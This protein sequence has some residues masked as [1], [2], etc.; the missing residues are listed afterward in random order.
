MIDRKERIEEE[1]E[2]EQIIKAAEIIKGGGIVAFPTETV[3]GLGANA[4]DEKAVRKIFELKGRPQDNPLIV[5]ICSLDDLNIVAS[6]I[7]DKAYKLIE[8]FWPGPL[9]LVLTRNP[10]V[11]DIVSS[12]L[13]TVAVRMP[14]HPVALKLIRYAGTPIAAPSAN[15]S[16]KP[17]ATKPE[18]IKHYFGE[19]VFIVEGQTEIGIESTVLDMTS[20]QVVIL[21]PGGLELEKIREVLKEDIFIKTSDLPK[22]PGMKY[23]HYKPQL[24][25]IVIGERRNISELKKLLK[26]K[27]K[28][29]Y[30]ATYDIPKD[31]KSE[32]KKVYN[33]DFILAGSDEKEIARNFFDILITKSKGYDIMVFES[34]QEKGVG[35]GI[36]NRLKKAADIII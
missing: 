9:T 23:P 5:H 15:P 3:Y 22:S 24:Y 28:I 8:R 2:E 12:G 16:G 35:L 34:V 14:S 31:I 32:L 27:A 13:T 10:S 1:K 11:P 6:N 20:D 19:K 21:R 17:S 36:M 7:P 26:P 4:F 33:I 25:F 29:L 18:H 30:V